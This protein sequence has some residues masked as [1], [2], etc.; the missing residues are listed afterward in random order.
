VSPPYAGRR[1]PAH[2]HS[3]NNQCA[4]DGSSVV[5][6]HGGCTNVADRLWLMP[7]SGIEE[8]VG[9]LFGIRC[10]L[11]AVPMPAEHDIPGTNPAGGG[12]SLAL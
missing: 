8:E 6:G 1:V 7:T 2:R 9:D 10:P 12:S 4:L 5:A 11:S 3:L